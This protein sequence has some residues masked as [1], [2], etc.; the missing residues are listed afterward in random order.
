MVQTPA[1]AP[2]ASG[3]PAPV[4][5]SADGTQARRLVLSLTSWT[6][7]TQ[8]CRCP[9]NRGNFT[10]G[11]LA[12]T[13]VTFEGG[14]AARVVGPNARAA[15]RGGAGCPFQPTQGD[16]APRLGTRAGVVDRRAWRMTR[17][18]HVMGVGPLLSTK[19]IASPSAAS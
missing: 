5:P 2:P 4:Q 18:Y 7:P 8:M 6:P 11:F 15:A 1:P 3:Q 12:V 10:P 9:R 13:F 17:W 14:R 16:A 19:R